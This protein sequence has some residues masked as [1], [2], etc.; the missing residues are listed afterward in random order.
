MAIP[1]LIT[2]SRPS[3]ET[4]EAAIVLHSN[5][6]TQFEDMDAIFRMITKLEWVKAS[7]NCYG[8]SQGTIE[9]QLLQ[10]TNQRYYGLFQRLM[11]GLVFSCNII[12]FIRMAMVFEVTAFSPAQIAAYGGTCGK[13]VFGL[14]EY[15]RLL[16]AH[17][18]HYN[19]IHIVLNM[20]ALFALGAKVLD[21]VGV[22]RFG[23]V[24]TLSGITA[25]LISVWSQPN[26]V[27]AGSSGAISGLLATLMILR[28]AGDRTISGTDIILT[29]IINV[30]ISIFVPGVDWPAHL[31]GFMVGACLTCLSRLATVSR[32]INK[33]CRK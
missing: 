8:C 18:L 17:Y 32:S 20:L 1:S 4:T 7:K 9:D 2:A 16:T 3:L 13:L 11:L 30:P 24:Y 33:I 26:M 6:R 22:L 15:W 19:I 23:V 31:A 14:G 10:N 28:A 21:R 12:V 27:G 25:S 29:I 5:W